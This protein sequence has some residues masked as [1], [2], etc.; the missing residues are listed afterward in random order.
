M[1]DSNSGMNRT[2]QIDNGSSSRDAFTAYLEALGRFRQL[3]KE[4]ELEAGTVIQT[5][6][7]TLEAEDWRRKLVSANLR[8]VVSV[9]K[10]MNG[11][12]LMID[13]LVCEGNLGLVRA[14]ERY[15]PLK[16]G[17]RFSTYAFMWISCFMRSAIAKART[18]PLPTRRAA[19]LAKVLQ[20]PSF[21]G[22]GKNEDVE[23]LVWE[24]G[25]NPANV[26]SCLQMPHC[27]GS[28]DHHAGGDDDAERTTEIRD[29]AEDPA[30]ALARKEELEMQMQA[31]EKC[32]TP[33]EAEILLRRF[34]IA[35]REWTLKQ[36][37]E[38]QGLTHEA[39]RQIIIRALKKLRSHHNRAMW[40]VPLVVREGLGCQRELG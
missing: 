5:R 32:L 15:N 6:P 9:A 26:Q 21:R 29:E 30:A 39:I 2:T 13:D 33:Q 34:G 28:L 23:Q 1:D 16:F 20:A 3:T 4:E 31:I 22:D 37:A 24:T 7:R 17:T 36:L 18:I 38:W 27:V 10:K 14:A 19:D 25:L 40:G 12:G 35:G 8:L 11:R